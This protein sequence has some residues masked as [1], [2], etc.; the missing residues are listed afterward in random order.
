MSAITY[1]GIRIYL[2]PRELA[3]GGWTANFTLSEERGSQTTDTTFHGE[4]TYET[5]ELAERAAMGMARRK[6]DER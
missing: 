3:E 5:K 2:Q 6:I 4:L 1:K